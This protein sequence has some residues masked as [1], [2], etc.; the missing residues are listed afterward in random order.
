MGTRPLRPFTLVLATALVLPLGAAA[1]GAES[2][3]DQGAGSVDGQVVGSVTGE[4]RRFVVH[5]DDGDAYQATVV[6]PPGGAAVRVED[7]A[8]AFVP[9]GGTVRVDLA[10]YTAAGQDVTEA[11]GGALVAAVREVAPASPSTATSPSQ[12]EA[13]PAFDG[14]PRPVYVMTATIPGQ[15]RDDVRTGD[16]RVD[17]A[18]HADP[19]FSD[20]TD[21][22][23]RLRVAGGR[24]AGT[25]PTWGTKATCSYRSIEAMLAWASDRAG[26]GYGS[27]SG[28]HVLLYTPTVASCAGV[29]GVGEVADGGVAWVNGDRT[30]NPT[31]RRDVVLQ[32]LGH[33]LTMALSDDRFG[34]SDYPSL[35]NDGF[36]YECWENA[37]GGDPYDVMGDR[38]SRGLLNAAQLAHLGV[39]TEDSTDTL[40]ASATVVLRPRGDLEGTRI[41]TF[42][43]EH[44]TYYVEYRTGTGADSLLPG[45][46]EPGVTVHRRDL[47]TE[48]AVLHANTRQPIADPF[49]GRYALA[50]GRSFQ[51]ADGQAMVT[52]TSV[53]ATEAVVEI[54]LAPDPWVGLAAVGEA[55][56]IPS[57]LRSGRSY[58]TSDADVELTWTVSPMVQLDGIE[59]I[60]DHG[61]V[62]VLPP[63]A[64]SLTVPLGEAARAFFVV[65]AMVEGEE[66]ARSFEI[67]V[68]R[69][70]DPP[71]LEGPNLRLR[72]GAMAGRSVPARLGWYAED[73]PSDVV[74][75]T[76]LNPRRTMLPRQRFTWVDQP[77]GS[78]V[79]ALRAEDPVGNT[80]TKAITR[81]LDLT[82]DDG[83]TQ[84][85]AWA[86][87][88]S[89]YLLDGQAFRS[90]TAGAS[91]T[92]RFTG[93]AFSW[94]A[95]TGPTSGRAAVLVDGHR[96]ATVDLYSPTTRYRQVVMSHNLTSSAPHVVRLV[97]E[98][99]DGR[100]TVMS[101]GFAVLR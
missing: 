56:E 54:D 44:A 38:R 67:A 88:Q 32:N 81:T 17:V 94:I 34:C 66:T 41:A 16:L 57:D 55:V 50:P 65:Q 49:V 24:D 100:P 36:W 92:L 48:S 21:G 59:V 75:V 60:R 74:E 83:T 87:V 77:E 37:H 29:R 52:T 71:L 97:V 19:Y 8:L 46:A 47:L 25:V 72:T 22:A 10:R 58:L 45:E 101:D 90:S 39:L 79:W 84:Q 76:L 82:D 33:T 3:A 61:R 15:A 93:R 13:L 42:S 85:G 95:T 1:A 35:A 7:E 43:T 86:E 5:L 69:D 20:S 27:G 18:Q 68:T 12:A 98:G 91:S 99:T 73:V 40:A 31:F 26:A 14:T 89:S 53:S 11:A 51:T 23:V 28:R 96:V 4:V 80:T 2:S 63:D 78:K 6:V 62:A 9:T 30:A 70:D 64:R